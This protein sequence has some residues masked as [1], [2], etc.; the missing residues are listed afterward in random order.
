MPPCRAKRG[1]DV[2]GSSRLGLKTVL[3]VLIAA[4]VVLLL[5]MR[6]PRFRMEELPGP[7]GP[8]EVA[9]PLLKGTK[10]LYRFRSPMEYLAGLDILWATYGRQNQSTLTLVL[11]RTDT[12]L[13][14]G[15]TRLNAF[16]ISDFSFSRWRFKPLKTGRGQ[17]LDLELSSP[18]ANDSSCLAVL[19]ANIPS[20]AITSFLFR[21]NDRELKGSLPVRLVAA[22]PLTSSAAFPGW[23]LGIGLIGLAWLG[24]GLYSPKSQDL[25]TGG[26]VDREKLKQ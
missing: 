5:Q 7:D 16:G 4:T 17:Q 12:G 15:R 2:T 9:G 13:V 25:E 3:A 19:V 22:E 20:N 8:V 6:E 14:L 11:K 26:T 24:I 18:D 21:V 23:L 1:R 10:V